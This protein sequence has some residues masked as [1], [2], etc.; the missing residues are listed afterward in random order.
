MNGLCEDE[1]K[2]ASVIVNH[3]DYIRSSQG[4]T[5]IDSL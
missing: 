2:L 4:P 3:E 5:E 1:M